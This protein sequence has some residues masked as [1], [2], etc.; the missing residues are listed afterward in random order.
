MKC[1]VF[2]LIFLLV[3]VS[4]QREIMCN[5]NGATCTFTSQTVAR[6]ESVT[7]RLNPAS[8]KPSSITAVYFRSSYIYAPPPE[9]FQKF[10]NLATLDLVGQNV[11]EV[12]P[13]TFVNAKK[14]KYV[15]F[16]N[17]KL[18]QINAYICE[19]ATSV[20]QLDFNENVLKWVDEDAFRGSKRWL[21]IN[22]K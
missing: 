1:L 9:L 3:R 22:H 2:W 14:I 4:E 21:M 16:I 11:Y 18:T 19:G 5:V 6:N 8:A 15:N 17:N 10:V 7:I 12:R 13:K 20:T